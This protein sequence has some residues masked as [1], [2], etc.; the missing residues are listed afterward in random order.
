M[1]LHCSG[2]QFYHLVQKLQAVET[3]AAAPA[4]MIAREPVILDAQASVMVIAKIP[5]AILVHLVLD[6][7]NISNQ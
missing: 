3:H 5:A 7:S 4:K 6:M 1:R 2:L